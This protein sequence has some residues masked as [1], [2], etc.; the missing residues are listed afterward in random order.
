VIQQK[1][2][3]KILRLCEKLE[4]LLVGRVKF[5]IVVLDSFKTL[6]AIVC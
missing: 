2:K 4:T 3:K 6:G 1:N 5:V